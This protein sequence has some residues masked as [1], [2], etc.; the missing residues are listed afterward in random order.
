MWQVERWIEDQSGSPGPPAWWV[1]LPRKADALTQ[2]GLGEPPPGPRLC[3]IG[4]VAW[5]VRRRRPRGWSR[6]MRRLPPLGGGQASSFPRR[7]LGT[8]GPGLGPWPEDV[9]G[10]D[11]S[12]WRS[13]FFD[14]GRAAGSEARERRRVFVF[15]P[16][17]PCSEP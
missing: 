7:T 4:V 15:N 6:G 14:A 10:W 17:G 5:S 8:T 12:G 16:N 1:T 2:P 3:P 13:K 9:R 11:L